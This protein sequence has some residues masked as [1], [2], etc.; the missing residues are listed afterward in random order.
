MALF[1]AGPEPVDALLRRT[2]REGVRVDRLA[3]LALDGVV[4]DG[5]RRVHGVH[6]V[7]EAAVAQA[8][9]VRIRILDA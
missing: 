4:T 9:A 8:R 7:L 2:V 1:E 3:G 6:A 5:A